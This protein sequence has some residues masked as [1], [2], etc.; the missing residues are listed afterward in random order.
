M[1][2]VQIHLREKIEASDSAA[3]DHFLNLQL[4]IK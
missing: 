4:M 1:S 2:R 3:N